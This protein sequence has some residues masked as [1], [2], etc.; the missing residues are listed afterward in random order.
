MYYTFILYC[1]HTNTFMGIRKIYMR[2]DLFAYAFLF[3]FF[4]FTWRKVM[5]GHWFLLSTEHFYTHVR[6]D[7]ERHAALNKICW[8]R[9]ARKLSTHTRSEDIRFS[10]VAM[11]DWLTFSFKRTA[12]A[13]RILVVLEFAMWSSFFWLFFHT[14]YTLYKLHKFSLCDQK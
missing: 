3:F 6:A 2:D 8:K 11:R 12:A 7:D 14:K 1:T 9:C 5:M 4:A 10:L 13:L